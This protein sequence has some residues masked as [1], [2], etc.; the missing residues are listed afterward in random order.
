MLFQLRSH[1]RQHGIDRFEDVKSAWFE[2]D[3]QF[4]FIKFEGET[5]DAPARKRKAGVG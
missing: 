3:G 5:S 2:S 1:L 4:S